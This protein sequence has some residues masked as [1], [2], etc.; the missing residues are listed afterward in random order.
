MLVR[1]Q[2]ARF[3]FIQRELEPQV[4]TLC[5]PR[6]RGSARYLCPS[7]CHSEDP[8]LWSYFKEPEATLACPGLP[9]LPQV[10]ICPRRQLPACAP[11]ALQERVLVRR[12]EEGIPEGLAKM[13]QSHLGIC[14]G[15]RSTRRPGR[16]IGP[17]S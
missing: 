4:R 9:N 15:T 13:L 17:K 14:A 7:L 6:P 3:H 12:I 5:Q 8:T 16:R 2:R 11:C 10:P 1:Q